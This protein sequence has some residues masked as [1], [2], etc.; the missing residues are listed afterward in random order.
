MLLCGRVPCFFILCCVR[1]N[2]AFMSTALLNR[3]FTISNS[4]FEQLKTYMFICVFLSRAKLR[5]RTRRLRIFGVQYDVV[6]VRNRVQCASIRRTL[7]LEP[8]VPM[9]NGRRRSFG[10]VKGSVSYYFSFDNYLMFCYYYLLTFTLSEIH[11]YARC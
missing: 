8:V 9:K 5:L 10:V 6:I 4:V 1:V 2:Y 7:Q 3:R 11:M